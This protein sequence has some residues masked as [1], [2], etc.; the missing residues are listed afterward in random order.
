MRMITEMLRHDPA[1][2]LG[3]LL[4]GVSAVLYNHMQMN[5][6][7]EGYK[8]SYSFFIPAVISPKAWTSLT[9]YLRVRSKHGWS[10]W[11]AYLIWPSFFVGVALLLFGMFHLAD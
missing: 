4:V 5:M 10:P 2:V 8:P 3:F 6:V 11:P 7:R 1:L 9:E